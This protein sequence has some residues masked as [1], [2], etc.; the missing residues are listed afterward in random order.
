MVAG[1]EA[2]DAGARLLDRA[3]AFV[4][5]DAAGSAG[6]DV[7]LEDVQVRA[8]DV[9]FT[10]RTIASVAAVTAG[11]GRSSSAFLPGPS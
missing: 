4:A 3:Y 5:E 8:A 1:R 9:V 2:G 6:R 7:A 10:I 11:I